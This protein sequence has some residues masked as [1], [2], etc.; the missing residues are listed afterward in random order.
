[1]TVVVASSES[2]ACVEMVA[3]DAVRIEE[4]TSSVPLVTVV[5]LP[6]SVLFNPED[7]VLL[8]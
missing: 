8:P 5:S 3:G 1:M 2:S 7:S 6:A 4:A